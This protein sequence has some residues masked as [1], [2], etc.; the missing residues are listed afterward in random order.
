ML[1]F[2]PPLPASPA[3]IPSTSAHRQLH[4]TIPPQ[5]PACRSRNRCC[6]CRRTA[7][8]GCRLSDATG[9][10][11]HRL[12]ARRF[13]R[14]DSAADRP[15]AIRSLNFASSGIGSTFHVAGEL[16]K[17]MAGVDIVHVPYRGGAPSLVDL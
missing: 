15:M 13:S 17:M 11:N 16:F 6:S 4:E 2:P 10:L 12:S 5:I 7:G 3:D 8:F 14:H 9:A 1:T